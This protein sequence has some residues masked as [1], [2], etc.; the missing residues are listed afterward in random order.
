M[1]TPQA[2]MICLVVALVF[3][4]ACTCG[5][6]G[7]GQRKA[8]GEESGRRLLKSETWDE[9]R[10][11]AH[12]TLAYDGTARASKGTVTNRT[13]KPLSQ[14]RV[15]VHLSNGVELG[16]TKRT[17]LAPGQTI[18]VE[19]S[20]AGQEFEWWTTHPEHGREEGHGP[21]HEEESGEHE[22][23]EGRGEHDGEHR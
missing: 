8:E 3:A 5:G 17:D 23:R 10:G 13:E 4:P 1:S 19:L 9:T 22:G 12:L 14:V 2:A 16:P 20:A 7:E 21:G 15:E 6:D 18:P 11:G